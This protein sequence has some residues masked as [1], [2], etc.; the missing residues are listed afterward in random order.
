MRRRDLIAGIAG[1]VAGWSAVTP[2]Q[3]R[4]P[5]DRISDTPLIARADE[6]IE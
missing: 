6:V 5:T 1:S 3:Q 4:A 2:A